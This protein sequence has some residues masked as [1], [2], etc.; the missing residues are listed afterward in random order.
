MLKTGGFYFDKAIGE[1]VTFPKGPIFFLCGRNFDQSGRINLKRVG[2]SDP[3]PAPTLFFVSLQLDG[4]MCEKWRL[5]MD[6]IL[7]NRTSTRKR[8]DPSSDK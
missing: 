8:W 7:V 1:N 5:V 3:F 2:N 6:Q 4:S